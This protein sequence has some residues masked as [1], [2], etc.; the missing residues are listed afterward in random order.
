MKIYT[1]TVDGRAE[2]GAVVGRSG[3]HL[4]SSLYG[5]PFDLLDPPV[6]KAGRIYGCALITGKP[7]FIGGHQIFLKSGGFSQ[8]GALVIVQHS[9]QNY[10]WGSFKGHHVNLVSG[11]DDE[12]SWC[13]LKLVP[14]T[15]VFVEQTEA[16]FEEKRFWRLKWTK[17]VK[18]VHH[19]RVIYLPKEGELVVFPSHEQW[20][21]FFNKHK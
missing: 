19:Y 14:E 1:V 21:E 17:F 5:L 11:L 15:A 8:D 13:A 18:L 3:R 20:A 7:E 6:V 9:H 12:T 10:K 4:Y 2:E 16:R